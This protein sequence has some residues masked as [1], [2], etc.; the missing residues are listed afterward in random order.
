MLSERTFL[1]KS[2]VFNKALGTNISL[3]QETFSMKS[4]FVISEHDWFLKT[5]AV[6]K[7]K[8]FAI[9]R[10]PFP[11]WDNFKL[12]LGVVWFI[13]SFNT[14]IGAQ[15]HFNTFFFFVYYFSTQELDGDNFPEEANILGSFL[16]FVRGPG[17]DKVKRKKAAF[18]KTTLCSS[19]VCAIVLATDIHLLFQRQLLFAAI[20]LS[21]FILDC[22]WS[23]KW[24]LC[25]SDPH[26]SYYFIRHL[27][28]TELRMF[29]N[30]NPLHFIRHALCDVWILFYSTSAVVWSTVLASRLDFLGPLSRHIRME[31]LLPWSLPC[32]GSAEYLA[33][34]FFPPGCEFARQ[35]SS[36]DSQIFCHICQISSRGQII[37]S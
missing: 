36:C 17:E 31:N 12:V 23:V 18:L 37:S 32:V 16:T 14:G 13:N 25:Q 9:I 22:F 26:S 20:L 2:L 3:C 27:V 30:V 4:Y 1:K 35:V 8:T 15:L 19:L 21:V 29:V 28:R 7:K 5:N 6:R 10:D 33:A 24:K 11:L 34:L